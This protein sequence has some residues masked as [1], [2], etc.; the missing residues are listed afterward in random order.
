MP[1][2]GEYE[3]SPAEWVRKQVE[4]YES[5]GGTRGT[6]LRGVPVIILTTLG[7]KSGKIRKSPLMRVEHEGHYAA[8]ASLGGAPNHP[9]WFHNIV[10]HPQVE[11]QDG[12]I[13]QDM[14]ARE[15]TGAEKALWW[16]RAVAAWPDY[17]D[18]QKKTEREIPVFVLDPVQTG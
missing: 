15:V 11:L 10:A 1:L 12:P 8:V 3:P 2:T 6:E 16:E 4:E 18:Y 14:V 7:V 9:V 13:R 5:S 17:A